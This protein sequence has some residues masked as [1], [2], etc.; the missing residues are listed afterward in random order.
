MLF[1]IISELS[2]QVPGAHTKEHE[3]V[4]ERAFMKVEVKLPS[5]P[6]DLLP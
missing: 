3:L 5:K 2:P 6:T 4:M 1:L